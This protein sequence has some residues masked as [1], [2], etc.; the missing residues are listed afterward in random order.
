MKK[1]TY[2]FYRIELPDTRLDDYGYVMAK[3]KAGARKKTVTALRRLNGKGST[4]PKIVLTPVPNEEVV[5]D[6]RSS[7]SGQKALFEAR[8]DLSMGQP[9]WDFNDWKAIEK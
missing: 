6:I 4:L 7:K 5:S 2:T 8:T 3:N 1:E 9:V